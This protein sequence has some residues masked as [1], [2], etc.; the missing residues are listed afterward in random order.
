MFSVENN[1][2]SHKIVISKNIRKKPNYLPNPGSIF[3]K[4]LFKSFIEPLILGKTDEIGKTALT[5]YHF[6]ENLGKTEGNYR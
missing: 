4:F 3:Q 1:A 2:F 6:S 5:Q